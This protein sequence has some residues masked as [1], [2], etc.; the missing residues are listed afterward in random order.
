MSINDDIIFQEGM[1]QKDQN[2]VWIMDSDGDRKERITP[3]HQWNTF[4]NRAYPRW[5]P[6][7][8]YIMYIERE[9]VNDPFKVITNRLIIQNVFTD[10]R[11]IHKFPI[12]GRFSGLAWMG[13]D[14][15]TLFVY[16]EQADAPRNIYRYNMGVASLYPTYN[17]GID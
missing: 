11:T 16:R 3:L 15:T 13:N 8:K 10:R 14:E 6:S 9:F 2:K 1:S 5:S 17:I 7:G 4:L 12:E